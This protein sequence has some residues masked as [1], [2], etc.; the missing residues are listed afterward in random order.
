MQDV[1]KNGLGFIRTDKGQLED[2]DGFRTSQFTKRVL[3]S[4]TCVSVKEDGPSVL[5]RSTQDPS[6]TTVRFTKDE[7]H[8]FVRGVKAGDFDFN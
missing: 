2:S 5:V 6:K 3:I 8:A 4:Y 1:F 7:W